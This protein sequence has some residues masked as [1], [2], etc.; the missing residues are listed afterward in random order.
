MDPIG[1]LAGMYE[2]F[3]IPFSDAAETSIRAY[4]EHKP[5]GKFGS[6]KYDFS[7]TGLDRE[8]ERARFADYQER[9]GV[10]SEE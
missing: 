7:D 3:G 4:L 6:H 10:P 9:Y 5:K 8:T 1:T 2:H